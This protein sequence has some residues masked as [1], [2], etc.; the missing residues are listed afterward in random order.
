M[1]ARKYNK[2]VELW[3]TAPSQNQ[4]GGNVVTE[5]LITRTWA[6]IRTSNSL[7]RSTDFGVTDTND[8]IILTLRK[9]NDLTYNSLNQYFKYRGYKWII[10][11][12]RINV[13]FEDREIQITLKRESIKDANI[14][15]PIGGEA[16][17]YTFDFQ[18][19]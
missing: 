5:T 15:P 13:G 14:V 16:F 8:T 10:Q 17:P 1:R 2:R 4:Y 3:Q 19:S 9:R 12:T 7:S 18:L 11:G 6:N